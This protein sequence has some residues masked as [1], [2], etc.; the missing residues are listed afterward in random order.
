[1]NESVRASASSRETS[2][3]GQRARPKEM[4]CRTWDV[5]DGSVYSGLHPR[6]RKTA[7]FDMLALDWT[8]CNW[9]IPYLPP[10]LHEKRRKL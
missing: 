5:R 4:R 3:E 10:Q 6:P 2:D 9:T 7:R 8:I 1:M